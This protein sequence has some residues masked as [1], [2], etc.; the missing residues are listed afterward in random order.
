MGG[1]R[2]AE[3]GTGL[4]NN[5]CPCRISRNRG[6]IHGICPPS[7]HCGSHRRVQWSTKSLGPLR[8]R[9]GRRRA[10]V[11]GRR[12]RNRRG[13]AGALVMGAELA[14][15]S[16]MGL[17]PPLRPRSPQGWGDRLGW[18]KPR[19]LKPPARR[20]RAHSSGEVSGEAL[21]RPRREARRAPPRA[22]GTAGATWPSPHCMGHFR[23]REKFVRSQLVC[24]DGISTSA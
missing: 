14:R 16:G 2:R 10:A 6:G 9:T 7:G 13:V 20:R 5:T 21:R 1:F 12:D 15:D 8:S 22:R 11:V 19:L 17:A 18:A 3:D 23:K 4:D 24:V